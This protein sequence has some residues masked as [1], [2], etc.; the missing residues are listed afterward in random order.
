MGN[1][2][3]L[4]PLEEAE[5]LAKNKLFQTVT[6]LHQKDSEKMKLGGEKMATSDISDSDEDR[7][8]KK[9]HKHKKKKK[10]K[11][12]R[13]SSGSDDDLSPMQFSP[14][15]SD[16]QGSVRKRRSRTKSGGDNKSI[17]S[18]KSNKSNN[19]GKRSF[20]RDDIS[21]G[22]SPT[23][24]STSRG[25]ESSKSF[26]RSSS[27]SSL[28]R[29]DIS[30]DFSDSFDFAEGQAQQQMMVPPQMM[31]PPQMMDP[32]FRPPF[33]RGAPPGVPPFHRGRG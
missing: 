5:M 13:H 8:K 25:R 28:T 17:K 27:Y 6:A 19:S 1:V 32:F 18:E 20:S 16:D 23:R 26:S 29:S 11:S 33:G 9:K 24:R 15:H 22:A 3:D 2:E 4:H 21:P 30:S 31:R 7:K 10:K 12:K 14:T